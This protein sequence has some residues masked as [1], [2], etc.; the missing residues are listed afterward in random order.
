MPIISPQEAI[1]DDFQIIPSVSLLEEY[2]DNILFRNTD[3]LDDFIT[4]LSPALE[5]IERTERLDT[6]LEGIIEAIAYT[7]N[8]EF[9]SVD[10]NFSWILQYL[11]SQNVNVKTDIE[12]VKDSRVDRDIETTGLILGTATREQEKY[13]L[14]GEWGLSEK[15]STEVTYRYFEEDYDDPEFNEYYSHYITFGLS[16]FLSAFTK[17]TNFKTNVSYDRYEFSTSSVQ[18]YAWTFGVERSLSEIFTLN[19]FLGPRYAETTFDTIQ[20]IQQ[21]NEDWGGTG[22][23]SLDYQGEVAKATITLMHNLQAA[24]GSD[25]TTERTG[26]ILDI[27]RRFSQEIRGGFWTRYFRNQSNSQVPTVE[28][29]DKNNYHLGSYINYA[30]TENL[31]LRFSYSFTVIEDKEA[32]TE[33]LRNRFFIRLYYQYPLFE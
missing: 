27:N 2:N 3:E 5:L 1:G 9:N 13:S 11:L 4:T 20:F 8:D 12:Y 6:R 28:N 21:T 19:V 18:N 30:F 7:D 33:S 16:H 29:I 26:A 15:T 25:G 17:P 14:T 22:H 31:A 24:S 32:D 10:Q 23:I